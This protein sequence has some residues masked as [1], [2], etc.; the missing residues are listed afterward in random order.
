MFVYHHSNITVFFM[1]TYQMENRLMLQMRTT[2]PFSEDMLIKQAADNS[3][4]HSAA[5]ALHWGCVERLAVC[6]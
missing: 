6:S 4:Y 1:H 2:P 5:A 3:N